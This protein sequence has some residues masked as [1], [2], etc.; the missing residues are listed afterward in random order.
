MCHGGAEIKIAALEPIVA[1]NTRK[2]EVGPPSGSWT[3]ALARK[4]YRPSIGNAAPI[5]GQIFGAT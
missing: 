4:L 5:L 2:E 1:G 3:P